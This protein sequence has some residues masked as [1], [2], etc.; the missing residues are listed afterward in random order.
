MIIII[1]F[2]IYNFV[3]PSLSMKVISIIKQ[4]FYT[5]LVFNYLIKS[6]YFLNSAGCLSIHP[7]P[8]TINARMSQLG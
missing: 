8:H 4:Y 3:L 6:S 5:I 2:Y 7:Y 1:S